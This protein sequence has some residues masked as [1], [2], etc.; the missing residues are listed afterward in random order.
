MTYCERLGIP[1]PDLNK[2]LDRKRHKLFH[3]VIIALLEHGE[4]MSLDQLVERMLDADVPAPSGDMAVSIQKA[5]HGLAPVVKDRDGRYALDQEAF[6]LRILLTTLNLKAI[7]PRA[8]A[9]KVEIEEPGDD[10][11]LTTEEVEAAL[12]KATYSA[13]SNL[14][15]VAALLDARGS[16][17]FLELADHIKRLDWRLQLTDLQHLKASALVAVTDE[18]VLSLRKTSPDVPA[19]RRAIRKLAYP[20]LR[21]RAE[22][23]MRK[24]QWQAH[25]VKLREKDEHEAKQAATLKRAV[26]RVFPDPGDVK[27][28]VILDVQARTLSTFVGDSGFRE[29]LAA[30]DVLVGLNPRDTLH[31]LGLDSGDYKL[32]DLKP[33]QK[34]RQL[35]RS[36]RK[37][38]ITT[39]LLISGTVGISR[40]LGDRKKTAAYLA[41]GE[42]GK[43]TRRLE[44]DAKHLFAYWNYGVLHGHVNLRWGF[45]REGLSVYFWA[46]PGDKSVREVLAQADKEGRQV[47]IVLGMSAPGWESPW[48]RAQ[49]FTV[50]KVED[51]VAHVSDGL[52]DLSVPFEEIQA[53]RLTPGR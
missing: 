36:G 21:R 7:P 26:I 48:S 8:P 24:E 3:A 40:A 4:P 43:L 20:V 52:E 17:S 44:S 53:I 5:W 51:R 39:E 10:V 37:L 30:Y 49:T 23:R 2:V 15:R 42:I 16:M 47:D 34:T 14:R 1:V 25:E 31:A 27:A 6:E 9:P 22:E 32:I 13:A 46:L 38:T 29:A 12:D 50:I 18:H 35:N 19:L 33:P 11:P 41:E 28:A 45:V